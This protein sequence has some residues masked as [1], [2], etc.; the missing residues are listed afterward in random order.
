[1]TIREPFALP[2]AYYPQRGT[3]RG[4]LSEAHALGDFTHDLHWAGFR[5]VSYKLLPLVL[6][7][8]NVQVSP[9]PGTSVLSP[10]VSAFN[11]LHILDQHPQANEKMLE[12][13]CRAHATLAAKKA[14]DM[15]S[16]MV[17]LTA[18]N[19]IR[20]S[21]NFD[22]ERLRVAFYG[23]DLLREGPLVDLV[24]DAIILFAKEYGHEFEVVLAAVDFGGD[25][26]HRPVKELKEYFKESRLISFS[27]E[28]GV[29]EKIR[30][31]RAAK[32]DIF[33]SFPGFTGKEDNGILLAARV[34]P[35]QMNWLEFASCM[36]APELVDFTLLGSAVGEGQRLCK[37]RERLITFDG[38]GSYQPPQSSGLVT[39]VREMAL[40][41]QSKKDR[42]FF[43]LPADKFI[44]LPPGSTNRF[45]DE[46][47]LFL[48]FDLLLRI[49]WAILV[50][51]EKPT[52]M[53]SFIL[54]CLDQYNAAR[55]IASQVDQ[56]RLIFR[57]WMNDKRV[58]WQFIRAVGHEG[59][60][61]MCI[62]SL[63]PV[64]FH[65]GTSDAMVNR[66]P[67]ATWKDAKGT[68]QQRVAAEI[69]ESA[70]LH[71]LFVSDSLQGTLDL[72]V[73]YARDP[74]LQDRVSD[75]MENAQTRKIGYWDTMRIPRG[76]RFG[77]KASYRQVMDAKGDMTQLRD[78]CIPYEGQPIEILDPVDP[79]DASA[80]KKMPVNPW[81]LLQAAGVQVDLLESGAQML[82]GIADETGCT[83]HEIVGSGASTFAIRASFPGRNDG[84]IKI[85]KRGFALS[86]LHNRPL[87]REA[88]ILVEWRQS[89][90]KHGFSDIL[91]E[92]YN[93]LNCKTACFGLSLP[94]AAG[95]RLCFLICEFIPRN[96]WAVAKPH[97]T[98][99][100]QTGE[101]NDALRI[102]VMQPLC[103]T[104]F[105]LQHNGWY[106]VVIRD[107]KPDNVR[108]RDN[109]S[110]A[111]TDLGS[112]IASPGLKASGNRPRALVLDR[113]ATSMW[114]N[115]GADAAKPGICLVHFSPPRPGDKFVVISQSELESFDRRL[116]V[117]G[118]AV[119]GGTTRGFTDAAQKDTAAK[120]RPL[121]S[122]VGQYDF[123]GGCFQDNFAVHRMVLYMLTHT[124]A[125]SMTDWDEEAYQAAGHG[126]DGITRMLL[127]RAPQQP[128]LQPAAFGRLV[129]FLADGLCANPNERLDSKAAMVHEC[130][131]L[132]MLTPKQELGLSSPTG[133]PFQHGPVNESMQLPSGFLASLHPATRTKV[134]ISNIPK[135]A[136]KI[137]EKMNGGIMAQEDV[138]GNALLGVYVGPQVRN[139]I[140]GT[141]YDSRNY[142]SRFTVTGHGCLK[143]FGQNKD[144]DGK[145]TCDAQST[146][147]LDFEFCRRIGNSGPFMNSAPSEAS[148]NCKVDRHS[149]WY[150]QDT[151]L[152]WMLVWAKAAG[153]KK[154]DYCLWHYNHEAG[155]GQLWNFVPKWKGVG[156]RGGEA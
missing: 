25:D 61:G 99:W 63:S 2:D 17:D 5:E 131:T 86:R 121:L 145:F 48:L 94:N 39:E 129:E 8:L 9:N 21:G 72:V 36:Y 71:R 137:Q 91:P 151:G 88:K 138:D 96:F 41:L 37:E 98:Q 101:L 142:P 110:M 106:N 139:H 59:R 108:F 51:L 31:L 27:T 83:L 120:V 116:G 143:I 19:N 29:E 119:V 49:P 1:M 104:V 15:L 20:N 44:L 45:K 42:E 153:I 132:A 76:L 60:R 33:I 85:S 52:T 54:K 53:K 35:L 16:R 26:V 82:Q 87:F 92:M 34:A 13:V 28:D 55:E 130:L 3:L 58:W 74:D 40:S 144:G 155:A 141:V 66:V 22:D 32:L 4:K 68:M 102:D 93:V 75:A 11:F 156:G 140:I 7:V 125:V 95:D 134:E 117:K 62:C 57:A 109:G 147:S 89:M 148:A 50:F 47:T 90:R 80:Q 64:S 150:D 70:G 56:T 107:L 79:A 103:H 123:K 124:P 81:N 67:L 152:I 12:K 97:Q 73:A 10:A 24:S 136:Y 30:M 128:I 111:V 100:Q 115:G 126:A 6:K 114:C 18:L 146:K 23:P 105:W 113:R 112:A 118:L 38:P 122:S 78:F 149:A 77:L 135:L 133:L 84:V 43:G 65:T 46:K 127:A 154:G 14:K 69:L